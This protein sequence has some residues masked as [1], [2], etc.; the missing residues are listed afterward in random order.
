MS[1][2]TQFRPAG[3]I[4]ARTDITLLRNALQ[5]Y[6]TTRAKY[7]ISFL[8]EIINKYVIFHMTLIDRNFFEEALDAIP[9][10]VS[11]EDCMRIDM[12][13]SK[14]TTSMQLQLSCLASNTS[15]TSQLVADP[16]RITTV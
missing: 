12:L 11:K 5:S 14:V 7:V 9:Q 2:V 8:F 4:Q 16:N 6:S 15:N 1:C 10:P 3:V 13:L